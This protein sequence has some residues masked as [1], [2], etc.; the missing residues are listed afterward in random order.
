LIVW[1]ISSSL[2]AIIR[3]WLLRIDRAALNMVE[4]AE[5]YDPLSSTMP[6]LMFNFWIELSLLAVLACLLIYGIFDTR[7]QV[8]RRTGAAA[9]AVLRRN[10]R[11]LWVLIAGTTV[12]LVG[13]V[14]SPLPGPGLSVLGPIGLAILA[15]E[16]VWARR[17]V[18]QIKE[19]S[20]PLREV[21]QRVANAS[22][23]WIVIPVCLAYWCGAVAVAV[24]TS[25]PALVLWPAASILF[26]PVFLWAHLAFRATRG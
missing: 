20:G 13:I 8:A 14:I 6:S 19:L 15:S 24:W 17:L 2:L 22:S 3:G 16:F 25:V 12:I 5:A 21:T 10:S 23:R 26:T 7:F 1:N 9:V 4:S 18:V 11:R